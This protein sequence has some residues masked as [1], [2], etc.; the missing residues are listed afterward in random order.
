MITNLRDVKD[1]QFI[2]LTHQMEKKIAVNLKKKFWFDFNSK[3][4][5]FSTFRTESYKGNIETDN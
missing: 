3:Y 5:A 4:L 2:I 1:E